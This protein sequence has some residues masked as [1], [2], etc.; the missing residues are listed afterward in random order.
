MV[1]AKVLSYEESCETGIG[2][3]RII[4]ETTENDEYNDN[5]DKD[6]YMNL[7]FKMKR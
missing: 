2:A 5:E 1:K 6:K 7:I 4:L 3:N